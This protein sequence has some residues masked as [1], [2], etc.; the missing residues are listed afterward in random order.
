MTGVEQLYQTLNERK[1]PEDVAEMIMELTTNYLSN[2]ERHIL[3]KAAK[4]SLSKSIYGYTSLLEVFA[5]AKGA[6]KQITK[7]IEIFEL[8]PVNKAD[9]NDQKNI[10]ILLIQFRQ[11]FINLQEKTILKLTD[12]IN[13]KEK[14][15]V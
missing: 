4:H 8:S 2:T 1:R 11:S 3:E 7:A 9:Y 12:L 14:I 5:E 15:K 6:E 10:E 13:P